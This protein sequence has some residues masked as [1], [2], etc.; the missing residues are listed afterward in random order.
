MNANDILIYGEG[1]SVAE[2]TA[3]HGDAQRGLTRHYRDRNLNLNPEKLK[4]Q[5]TQVPFIDH[6]LTNEGLKPDPG[7]A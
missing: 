3:D 4:L 5:C 2:A 1:V 7:K 6:L